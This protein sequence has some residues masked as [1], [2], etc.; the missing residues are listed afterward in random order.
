VRTLIAAVIILAVA[1]PNALATNQQP[2]KMLYKGK[3]YFVDWF[4]MEPY[5][6]KHPAKRP[7]G[8]ITSALWR[9]YVATSELKGK[10]LVLRDIE[11]DGPSGWRSAKETVVPK[12]QVLKIDWFTGTLVLYDWE[13]ER[14]HTRLEIKDGQVTD[15]RIGD[16][17][18]PT[19]EGRVS[20]ERTRPEIK[21]GQVTDKQ[22]RDPEQIRSGTPELLIVLVLLAILAVVMV[23]FVVATIRSKDRGG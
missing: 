2:D 6:R 5:F 21:D 23:I 13:A 22:I 9:G 15:E 10:S 4:L 1:V 14:V 12:G 7:R 11:I 8:W 17:P 20:P 18:E 16:E 3:E 19:K